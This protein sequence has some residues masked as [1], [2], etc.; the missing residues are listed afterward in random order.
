MLTFEQAFTIVRDTLRASAPQAS[1]ETVPLNEAHG[2]VL[3]DGLFAD[4]DYPPFDRATRDGFAVRSAD[5][6]DVPKML[7]VVGLAR[8]GAPYRGG[9]VGQG[10]T[11][12]IMT[13][14]PVPEG[15]D[16]VV[17]VEYTRE[18]TPQSS[19]GDRPTVRHVEIL[20]PVKPFDN[21]VHQGSEA[22]VG[23]SVLPRARRLGPGEI[24]LAAM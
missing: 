6:T 1:A 22:K 5:V 17:M 14:A 24:G 9:L 4:R 13:G 10:C 11:V 2:R 15:A 3:A 21:I 19:S 16:A 12:E 7:T 23:A 18:E 20:R 8:A